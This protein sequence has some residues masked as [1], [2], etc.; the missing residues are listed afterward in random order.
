MNSNDTSPQKPR[1]CGVPWFP[2]IVVLLALA[3]GTAVNT[4]PELERNFAG[5]TM[6]ALAILS[7]L[8]ILLWF[9]FTRRFAGR[10][11]ALGL[12]GVVLLALGL[13]FS[14][15]V[16]GTADG[17]GRPR[18]VWKW[19]GRP[20][21]KALDATAL[22]ASPVHTPSATEPDP[23][24]AGVQDVVQ[25]FGTNRDGRVDAP[26]LARDWKAAP[27]RELWRHEI[28]GGWSSFAVV[29]GHAWTQ[30][31]R[32]EQECVT[33]YD[34]FT[35]ALVWS[36]ADPARFTQWQ[37]GEGPRATPTVHDGKL[38][39]YGATGLLNG[40]D[41]ATGKA[42]WQR[43]VLAENTSSNIE[44]GLS[45]SPLVVDD[46]VV[47]TGGNT[48]GPVLFA[49]RR[50]TGAPVWKAGDDRAS[51]ASPVLATIAGR[52]VI[53]SNN[54]RGL[55]I[56][57]PATGAVLL[58]HAWGSD[59]WPKASQPVVVGEDRVFL[60]GGYGMGCLLLKVEARPGGTWS[61][62]EVW[63]GMRMKTQFNSP[64]LRDGH[65]Y[66]LD[67]GRLACVDVATG[68]RVWKD[69]NYASG[70]SLLV[71]DLIVIQ[72]EG[73][74]VHLCAAKVGGFEELGRAEA[75]SSK[76]WNLP[77]LAGRY[78]LVR[79]DREALCLELPV[80]P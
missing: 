44:W 30:E 2:I 10:T 77:V 25:F 36:H 50:D 62:T 70:Q 64:A 72:N 68:E 5:W 17:T 20:P 76:T 41:A 39:T 42:L 47:V 51:Y 26:R 28:G 67:D 45:A 33:C 58:D 55:S 19:A 7:S 12:A 6:T 43:A 49:Y 59:K 78:L 1:P 18:L 56:H 13:R 79:N 31:Q 75:L 22:A 65:L 4:R 35:G 61:A 71:N 16:D 29:K 73:G 57:D 9:T 53:L 60:S 37:G 54:A 27:P 48:R 38:Y 63:R 74:S 23:R 69:G 66:G 15:H 11:R 52:R 21:L 3:G 34:L 8:V 32:G 14:L 24:L 46:L 40:L 80:M